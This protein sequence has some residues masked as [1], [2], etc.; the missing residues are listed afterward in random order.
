MAWNAGFI[1]FKC[2]RYWREPK[3]YSCWQKRSRANIA[4]QLWLPVVAALPEPPA[5][6]GQWLILP[7][8]AALIFLNIIIVAIM[9]YRG[10]TLLPSYQHMSLRLNAKHPKVG[11]KQTFAYNIH[12]NKIKLYLNKIIRMGYHIILD[13]GLNKLDSLKAKS[14][15]LFISSAWIT[16]TQ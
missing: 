12:L 11:M 7:K 4:R 1:P 5:S 14:W 15:A 3:E 2:R 16:G 8:A 9:V 13:G 10:S 6:L